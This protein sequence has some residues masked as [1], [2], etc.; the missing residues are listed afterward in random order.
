MRELGARN[1][2]VDS[3]CVF[4]SARHLSAAMDKHWRNRYLDRNLNTE[5][6]APRNSKSGEKRTAMEKAV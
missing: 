4:E 6:M 2:L 1:E 3:G 5:R